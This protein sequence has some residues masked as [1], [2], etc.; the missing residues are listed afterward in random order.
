MKNDPFKG[1]IVTV[2]SKGQITIPQDHRKRL[3]M[4]PGDEVELWVEK[5][6]LH[7]RPVKPIPKHSRI[8]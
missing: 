3:G 6:S 7:V 1:R 5:G 4:Q 2:S 8:A